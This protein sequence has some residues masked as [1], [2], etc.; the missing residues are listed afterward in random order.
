M[1]TQIEYLTGIIRG[2]M[3]GLLIV[4]FLL[5]GVWV[6]AAKRRASFE[7]AARLPLEEDSQRGP[8]S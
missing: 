2:V 5:L 7:N 3:A 1:S 8:A 4:T 6:F